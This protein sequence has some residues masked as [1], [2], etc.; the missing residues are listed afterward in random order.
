M[1][2]KAAFLLTLACSLASAPRLFAGSGETAVNFLLESGSAR[3]EAMG[4]LTAVFSQGSE[5]INAG[6]PAGIVL[7]RRPELSS[8]FVSGQSFSQQGTLAYAHPFKLGF[9]LSAG[10]GVVYYNAGA[11]DIN[12][13]NGPTKSLTAEK[14]L[15]SAASLAARPFKFLAVGGSAKMIRSTLVEQY[16]GSAFAVD[17]GAIAYPALPWFGERLFVGASIQNLGSKIKYKSADND[18]PMKQSFGVAV[19]AY[20]DKDYGSFLLGFQSEQT[21]GEKIKNRFGGE[22]AYGDD[23]RAMFLRG[24][25]RMQFESEDWS[26]G[27]G[28]REKN[29]E[30]DYSFSNGIDL[31]HTHRMTISWKFGKIFPKVEEV[32]LLK[33][34][35]EKKE[36]MEL[37]TEDE[38]KMGKT[39][40][41]PEKQETDGYYLID[42]DEMEQKKKENK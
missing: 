17:A 13:S 39:K 15:A 29:F 14:G 28:F 20:E 24:G 19:R 34:E 21:K 33:G 5:S 12:D 26:F 8:S 35:Q 1:T 42:K 31:E 10:A 9:P 40:F 38:F 41:I 2:R 23:Y 4:G 32:M 27:L 22:Y 18:L 11:I 37:I 16:T 6:N 25:L 30:M 36:K 3:I 7:L